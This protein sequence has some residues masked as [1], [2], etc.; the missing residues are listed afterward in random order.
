MQTAGTVSILRSSELMVG[1][2]NLA[3]ENPESGVIKAC[4]GEAQSRGA[5]KVSGFQRHTA[6]TWVLKRAQKVV[7]EWKEGR[8]GREGKKEISWPRGLD[9]WAQAPPGKDSR[10][11]WLPAHPCFLYRRSQTQLSGYGSIS[12]VKVP[13]IHPSWT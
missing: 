4:T 2:H 5:R 11:T 8:H 9:Q 6:S 1:G 7:R 3:K 13:W 12:V 10:N